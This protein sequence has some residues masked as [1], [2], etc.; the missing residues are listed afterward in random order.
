M[1]RDEAMTRALA[2]FDQAIADRARANLNAMLADDVD[3]D[4]IDD[5]LELTREMEQQARTDYLAFVVG[6]LDN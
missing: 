4:Q 1:T 5:V 2:A 6:L 3:P